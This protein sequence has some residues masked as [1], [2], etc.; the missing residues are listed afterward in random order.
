MHAKIRTVAFRGIDTIPVDVQVHV[1]NGL[2]SMAIVGLADKAVAESKE[3]V[4][5]ALASIGLALPPKRIAINL[6]P[7]DVVKEGAHFDLPIALGLLVAIGSVPRDAIDGHMVLGELSLH[8]AIEPVSGVLP[9]AMAAVAA[10]LDLICPAGCGPEAA[11]ASDLS[12][13]AAPD[14]MALLNHLRGVQHLA[15]PQARLLP[16]AHDAPDLADLRGQETARRVLEIAAAGRHNLL[17]IGPP[18][19][20][21]SMLAARLPGLLPPLSPREALDVTMLH[22]I[23][24]QLSAGGLV[25]SRPFRD[26]HHSASMAALVG[27]GARAR[28]GEISLA[29]G[30][31]LFLDE[32]AEFAKPALDALRQPLETGQVVVARANHHVTYPAQFQLIAAMNPCRCGYLGDPARACTRA[33]ECGRTYCARVSGPMLDRFDMVIEVPE[34]SGQLLLDRTPGEATSAVARRVADAQGFAARRAPAPDGENDTPLRDVSPD[35]TSLL[36]L[37]IEKKSLSARGF[38]RVLRVARTI[39]DLQQQTVIE[40]GHLAEALGYRAMPLLA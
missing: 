21:K 32:L 34:V 17:M 39:A 37:A 18:G 26:P 40:R 4:R 15:V 14:L 25:Q 20:G 16:A 33:P 6:A 10:G 22:S 31:V 8:G 2:P 9:A 11:W 1:A 30:G 13:V 3:R 36:E 27:G 29:H 12:I 7:A 19:A 5:A 35:A 23:A 38:H 24:G 28:P